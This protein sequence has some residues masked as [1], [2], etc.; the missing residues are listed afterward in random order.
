MIHSL[1][2]A[3]G[4]GHGRPAETAAG[5]EAC[6]ACARQLQMLEHV[7]EA[8]QRVPLA[9]GYASTDRAGMIERAAGDAR[10]ADEPERGRGWP[11]R[12]SAGHDPGRVA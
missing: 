8:W 7:L 10:W 11:R 1:H 5:A 4:A 6:P 2:P 3:S 12:H 9:A